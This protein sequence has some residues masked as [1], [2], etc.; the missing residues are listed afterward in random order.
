MGAKTDT[1]TPAPPSEAMERIQKAVEDYAFACGSRIPSHILEGQRNLGAAISD[2]L[3]E[4]R[5]DRERLAY[6]ASKGSIEI[7]SCLSGRRAWYT[8]EQGVDV[9]GTGS[10]LLEAIDAARAETGEAGR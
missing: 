1:P 2:A 6:L 3:A 10:D 4:G 8:I 5:K 9:L 7:H